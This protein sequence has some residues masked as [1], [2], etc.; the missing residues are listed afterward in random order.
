MFAGAAQLMLKTASSV[1]SG[2][3]VLAG[4]GPLLL[5]VAQQL[6]EAG[7]NVAAVVE[8]TSTSDLARG[9]RHLPRALGGFEYL[10]KGMA[11]MRAI[12]RSGVRWIRG[13]SGLSVLGTDRAEGLEV[14][15]G[16]GVERFGADLVLL[17]A[18]VIPNT[19]L[20]RMMRLEHHWDEVQQSWRPRVDGW[21]RT[22]DARVS[23]A[24]DGAGIGGARVAEASGA[25]VALDA[26]FALGRLT[27]AERARRAEPLHAEVRRHLRVRPMLDAIY[28]VPAWLT[29]PPD[30]TIVCRCEE[31]TA[32][33]VRRMTALGCLGPNHTKAFSRCGMGP[34]Q[35]RMCGPTVSAILAA[36]NGLEMEEVGQYRIR[37]P[38]KPIPIGAIATL[39]PSSALPEPG[40]TT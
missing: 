20:T 1:P 24:G 2:R 13:V 11:M 10:A 40:E 3:V 17:H 27:E 14:R 8:T 31:V 28:R 6:L 32:G 34:C 7:A 26:A 4:A 15:S 35:G 21:G 25:I 33:E 23:V 22:S 5:L 29:C 18:G 16:S 30:E 19:Q 37:P 9:A 39:A 36:E 38:V 12:R